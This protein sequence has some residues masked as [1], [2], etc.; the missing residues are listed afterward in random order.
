M[1]FTRHDKTISVLCRR[2][3]KCRKILFDINMLLQKVAAL[4]LPIETM[5]TQKSRKTKILGGVAVKTE[6]P[7]RR[8]VRLQL[9]RYEERKVS[10]LLPFPPGPL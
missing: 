4:C 7:L 8:M 9:W 5:D 6:F 3:G 1:E 10:P 2:M